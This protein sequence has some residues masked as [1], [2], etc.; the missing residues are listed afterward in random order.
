MFHH[1]DE[2]HWGLAGPSAGVPQEDHPGMYPGGYDDHDVTTQGSH[3]DGGGGDGDDDVASTAPPSMRRQ[4]TARASEDLRRTASNVLSNI[5]SRITT[6]G[7][8][9][10]PPPPDG[11]VKAWTQVAC[12]RLTVKLLLSK[13]SINRG[14]PELKTICLVSLRESCL[15]CAGRIVTLPDC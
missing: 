3:E 13:I 7:W 6:R 9:E 2:K 8:P 10:P 14:S 15:R 11:G 4:R 5:A 1:D 12:V